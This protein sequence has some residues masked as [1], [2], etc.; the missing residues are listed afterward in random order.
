M[1]HA[2]GFSTFSSASFLTV[3]MSLSVIVKAGRDEGRLMQVLKHLEGYRKPI[4]RDKN[5]HDLLEDP[6]LERLEAFLSIKKLLE[7]RS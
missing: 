6:S 2:I 7:G 1:S 3:T 4:R 5:F